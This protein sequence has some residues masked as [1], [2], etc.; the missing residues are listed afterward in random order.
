MPLFGFNL[1]AKCKH[2]L[3]NIIADEYFISKQTKRSKRSVS[4]V[5]KK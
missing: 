3:T 4:S 5:D 1:T 2:S